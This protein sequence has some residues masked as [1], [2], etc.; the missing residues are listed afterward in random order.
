MGSR[1]EV[2]PGGDLRTAADGLHGPSRDP[3]GVPGQMSQPATVHPPE[4]GFNAIRAERPPVGAV[5]TPANQTASAPVRNTSPRP[6][7]A[8]FPP[9]VYLPCTETVTDPKDA[10]V[11]MR[12]T[13]DGR[14]ALLAY[15][16]L[17]RLRDCCGDKQAWIV[18]PTANLS[19]LQAARPFQLLMLDVE[20]PVDKRRRRS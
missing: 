20:I 19:Q 17:D 16:A 9:V 3:G 13:R 7:P 18:M 2:P 1:S 12:E 11:D 8:E 14:T 15:S 6:I 10:R 5:S 4:P